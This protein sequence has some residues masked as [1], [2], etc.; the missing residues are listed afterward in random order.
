[1]PGRYAPFEAGVDLFED[2]SLVA[3]PL[4]GHA[5]GQMGLFVQTCEHGPVFLIADACWQSKAY[6]DL[7]WP[8]RLANLI[9]ADPL[10]YRESLQ[11]VHLWHK[12]NP[13]RPVIPSH[14]TEALAHYGSIWRR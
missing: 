9:M 1:L 12:N 10:A 5:P 2:G 7:C 14:C 4:P 6:R 8:H 3:V 13:G 11:K